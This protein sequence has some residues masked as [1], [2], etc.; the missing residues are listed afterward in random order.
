MANIFELCSNQKDFNKLQDIKDNLQKI[1]E[2]EKEEMKK[3]IIE[4]YILHHIFSSYEEALDWGIKNPDKGILWH[5]KLLFWEE[6]K[7]KFKSYEQEFDRDGII[8]FDVVRYYT[9]EE[10]LEWIQEHIEQYNQKHPE[11]KNEKWWLDEYG[12]LSYVTISI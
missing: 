2:D 5:C 6:D 4:K 9:K 11:K 1:Q 8:P 3:R 10:L 7:Q 12:K